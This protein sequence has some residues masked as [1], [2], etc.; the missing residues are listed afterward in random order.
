[1]SKVIGAAAGLTM[2]AV[3]IVAWSELSVV[4]PGA[5]AAA[6]ARA[7]ESAPIISPFDAMIK[8]GKSLP[9]EDWRPAN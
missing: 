8:R 1:M 7:A 9:L 5:T 3:A 6:S 2:M 4:K